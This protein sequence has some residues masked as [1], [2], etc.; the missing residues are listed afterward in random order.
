MHN[1]ALWASTEL[2]VNRLQIAQEMFPICSSLEAGN[3]FLFC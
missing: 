1:V 2:M 3:V